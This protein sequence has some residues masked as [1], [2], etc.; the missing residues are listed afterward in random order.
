MAHT[1]LRDFRASAHYA[2]IEACLFLGP[3]DLRHSGATSSMT[4]ADEDEQ[5]EGR[6]RL[7]SSRVDF[8][9]EEHFMA[10]EHH[11]ASDWYGIED[12]AAVDRPGTWC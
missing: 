12:S 8:M 4:F 10:D 9:T 2:T 3:R 11:H 7:R 5:S 1:S 6:S